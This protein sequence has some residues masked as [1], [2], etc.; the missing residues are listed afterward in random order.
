MNPIEE[1]HLDAVL[2]LNNQHAVETSE[3]S[4]DAL[5]DMVDM[6][7]TALQVGD[8]MDGF[9]LTYADQSHYQ[10]DNFR[11]FVQRY[12]SF[13]YVDRIIVASSA[14]GHGLARSFYQHL[15][16][17]AR[18]NGFSHIAC[19]VNRV[20]PNPAS[21]AFHDALGF[22]EVGRAEIVGGAKLVRYLIKDLA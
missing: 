2:A 13:V 22:N 8:G 7:F 11:W 15:I 5:A 14:R 12:S 3:L 9:I 20:P 6:A 17:H 10:G 16:E 1:K 21:E 19:E 4:R 18:R